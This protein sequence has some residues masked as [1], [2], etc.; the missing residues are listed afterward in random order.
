MSWTDFA[1]DAATDFGKQAIKDL[2]NRI[3]TSGNPQSDHIPAQNE[4]GA[5]FAQVL[6]AY[7]AG[8]ITAEQARNEINQWNTA[9]L[10][11]TQ[12]IGSARALKGGSEINALAQRILSGLG[13]AGGGG[14][15]RP[16]IGSTPGAGDVSTTTVLLIAGAAAVLLFAVK[17]RR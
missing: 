3:R 17:G 5:K 4:T 15:I 7:N 14:P 1:K 11:L 9:F 2:G 16:P 13:G 12:Q 8:T 6:A 10:L